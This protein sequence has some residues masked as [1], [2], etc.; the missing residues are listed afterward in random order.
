MNRGAKV[1]GIYCKG[2]ISKTTLARQYL[3]IQK[4][5]VLELNFG[6]D[7]QYITSQGYFILESSEN[8]T[9]F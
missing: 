3:Q 8:F 4:I 6:M 1:I 5:Q 2:G 9:S 7:T